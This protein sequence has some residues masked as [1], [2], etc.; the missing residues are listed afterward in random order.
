[1]PLTKLNATKGLTGTLPAVSGANLTGIS[2]GITEAD[3]WRL[4]SGLS[5]AGDLTANFERV[6]TD[7]TYIGTG[8][9]QSSGIFT[10]PS[11]GIYKITANI[12]FLRNN[13][14]IGYGG[15]YIMSTSDNFSSEDALG[16]NFG[17]LIDEASTYTNV[18]THAVYDVTDLTNNKVKFKYQFSHGFTIAADTAANYTYFMFEKLGET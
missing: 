15:V 18:V 13:S 14:A 6:D 1:M 2:A 10:F 8:M 12:Q 5:T 9:T 11:T 16:D 4:T 7:S 3:Q 17:H